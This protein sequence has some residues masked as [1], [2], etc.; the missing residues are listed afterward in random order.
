MK[1]F[2]FLLLKWYKKIFS[3]DHGIFSFFF[4]YGFCKFYPSCSQYTHRSL[5]KYGTPKGLLMGIYRIL[6]CHPWSR[7]GIDHP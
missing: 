2:I 5:V 1:F 3:P 4:P 7:G 6:R